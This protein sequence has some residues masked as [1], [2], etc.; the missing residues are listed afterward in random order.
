[1][2]F[3]VRTLLAS[4]RRAL[5][6][7]ALCGLTVAACDRVPLFAPSGS[8]VSLVASAN[9]LEV[10]GSAE[11]TAFVIEGGFSAP[12]SPTAPGEVA[13]GVGTPVHDGTLVVF[14]TTLGRL[15]PTEAE[16]KDGHATVRLVGD[17]R[18]GTAV[19][20][21]FSGAATSTLE[22]AIGAAPASN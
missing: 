15:D 10:N 9:S 19:V 12:A 5:V 6:L 20:T 21:A 7:V 1:M 11:I 17:G 8:T 4:P 18:S 3:R 14:S 13:P 16:T 22:L 2:T